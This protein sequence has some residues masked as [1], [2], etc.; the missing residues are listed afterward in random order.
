MAWSLERWGKVRLHQQIAESPSA[1]AWTFSLYRAGER[2]PETVSDYFPC[3]RAKERWPELA[4]S[5]KRHAGD[6]R[7]H[8]MLYQKA[9]E[10]MGE[11]VLEIDDDDVFNVVI[12]RHTDARWAIDREDDDDTVRLKLAHFLAHAHQLEKRVTRS[13]AYHA[14]GCA[15]AGRGDA[16]STVERVLADEE[17]HVGYTRQAVVELTTPS[18]RETIFAVHAAGEAAADKAF[19]AHQ[20]RTFLA[21]YAGALRPGDRLFYA[22]AAMVMDA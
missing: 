16:R 7:R 5:M 17:R 19:S 1:H 4:A 21:R 6:E 9:I 14:E 3:E 18:E 20:L 11:P 10:R 22:L 15:R 8:A 2:H 13:L 12:R